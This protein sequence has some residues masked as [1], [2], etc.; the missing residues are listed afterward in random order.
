MGRD[1]C[2]LGKERKDILVLKANCGNV[3]ISFLNCFVLL[4]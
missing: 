4:L 1:K 2:L 3:E